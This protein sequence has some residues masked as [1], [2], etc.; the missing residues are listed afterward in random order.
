MINKIN[1]SKQN[2]LYPKTYIYIELL[3]N[4]MQLETKIYIVHV[5]IWDSGLLRDKRLVFI[6]P[7]Y[8]TIL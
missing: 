8:H 3:Y 1:K 6:D 4:E 5:P 7:I 2:S